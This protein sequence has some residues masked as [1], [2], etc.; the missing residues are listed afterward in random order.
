M[1]EHTPT[2]Y[3]L[4]G[5]GHIVGA[6]DPGWGSI[7][8]VYGMNEAEGQA[9]ARFFVRA[10]NSHANLLAALKALRHDYLR[11]LVDYGSHVRGDPD[12]LTLADDA[13]AKAEKCQSENDLEG[14]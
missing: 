6:K 5:A 10:C 3:R 2:P 13:I 7:A 1:S 11:M 4:I 8:A 14:S 12:V 9:T